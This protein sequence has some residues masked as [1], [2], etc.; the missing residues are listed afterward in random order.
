[1]ITSSWCLG[2][3]GN[4]TPGDVLLSGQLEADGIVAGVFA[5][6]VT[7]ESSA[8]IGKETIQAGETSVNVKT[9]AVSQDSKIF[10]TISKADEAVPIKTGDIKEGESFEVKINDPAAS[11]IEIS[12]WIVEEK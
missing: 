4:E 11:D 8:T 5:V 2:L 12:W 3:D 1:M 6:K 10:V 7:D 9:K